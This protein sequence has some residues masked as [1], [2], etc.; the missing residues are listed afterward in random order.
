MIYYEF[1]NNVQFAMVSTPDFI[2]K[3]ITTILFRNNITSEDERN[4]I[5]FLCAILSL[6]ILMLLESPTDN[7]EQMFNRSWILTV[8]YL[9][10]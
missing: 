10:G 4:R 3:S 6:S 1:T 7:Q 9:S 8:L 5:T 2:N